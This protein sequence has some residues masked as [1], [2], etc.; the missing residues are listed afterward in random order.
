MF[1]TRRLSALVLLFLGVSA[2][3]GLSGCAANL[4]PGGP[5]VAGFI[6]T[7]VKDPAQH[8]SVAVDMTARGTKVGTSNA[9]AFLGLFAFGD[10]SLDAAMK[11]GGITKVHH[12]DHQVQLALGGLWASTT[13]IV[14]GE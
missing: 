9:N 14:H 3:F 12:V 5:S 2:M 8:L 10:A 6:Y 11:A 7:D 13:T 4:Y 1:G